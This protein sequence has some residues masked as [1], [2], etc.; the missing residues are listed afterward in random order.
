MFP[1]WGFVDTLAQY[2][3]VNHDSG[4][5]A[6]ASNPYAAMPSLHSM[7]ALIVGIVMFGVVKS[8]LA[9]ALWLAWPA[10]VWFSV[11]ATANHFWLDIAAG[12]VVALIA[13]AVV[14]RRELRGLRRR[15]PQTA[16]T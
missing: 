8:R 16:R 14:Y 5:I 7:D 4:L 10:W 3:S 9:K 11:M 2:S 12:V 13:G 1:E 6:F 15:E